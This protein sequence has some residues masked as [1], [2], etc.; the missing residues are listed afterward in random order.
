MVTSR[1]LR[2]SP[3][4]LAARPQPGGI[5]VPT[6]GTLQRRVHLD[7]L[8]GMDPVTLEVTITDAIRKPM[9]QLT[10][11][12]LADL[13]ALAESDNAPKSLR[14]G[15]DRML[16]R[17]GREIA[18]VPD[19]AQWVELVQEVTSLDAARIPGWLRTHLVEEGHREGRDPASAE[20]VDE[21]AQGWEGTDPKPFEIGSGSAPMIRSTKAAKPSAASRSKKPVTRRATRKADP[22]DE[23]MLEHI[24]QVC[25]DRL[26]RYTERGLAEQVLLVGIR[27]Q[28]QS[29][30]PHVRG[31]H[32]LAALK[33]MEDRG[34][35]RKSAGR[36]I[37]LR[38]WTGV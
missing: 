3:E 13:V 2:Y 11:V 38:K 28:V 1:G 21:A 32:V 7:N 19:G 27:K 6:E 31:T 18:D 4:H 14:A 34:V 15:L 23:A 35:V 25:T 26:S 22:V 30:H 5:V 24:V 36:W 10:P 20:V 29:E 16:D 9:A 17:M 37:L 8:R 33:E 12:T